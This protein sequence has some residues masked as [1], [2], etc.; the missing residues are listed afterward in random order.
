MKKIILLT[1][2]IILIFTVSCNNSDGSLIPSPDNTL[3]EGTVNETDLENEQTSEDTPLN[4]LI[5]GEVPE[6]FDTV[7][8]NIDESAE[9]SFFNFAAGIIREV[10][11]DK[12]ILISPLSLYLALSFMANGADGETL[13]EMENLLEITFEELNGYCNNIVLK[14]LERENSNTKIANSLWYDEGLFT[15][16]ESFINDG[17]DYYDAAV[18]ED[19]F[20]DLGTVDRI[21]EWVSEKTSEL[22]N[23]FI[24]SINPAT[25]MI[26]INTLYFECQWTNPYE[27]SENNFNNLDNTTVTKNFISG[28]SYA[29]YYSENAKAVKIPMKDNFYM[30][31]VM[32]ENDI[33]DY[34]NAFDGEELYRLTTQFNNTYDVIWKMPV[35]SYEYDNSLKEALTALGMIRAF[36]NLQADFSK[37]GNDIFID[38][39]KQKTK[40][41]LD[42]NGIKAAAATFVIAFGCAPKN[43]FNLNFDRPFV[44]V[45]MD[46]TTDTPLFIG[47]VKNL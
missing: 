38:D 10:N 23:N 27:L 12:N 35:F 16:S 30:L 24:D 6:P 15:P 1:L 47:A 37:I 3:N 42:E 17:R 18:F 44:Y 7:F 46:D 20:N 4:L 13:S 41:E 34:L 9:L 28:R 32:P 5:N 14:L 43:Y 31:A 11:E 2:C 29:Y 36:N 45:I 39:V 40:I 26:L 22:I 21:N 8:E 33:N 25:I 19:D